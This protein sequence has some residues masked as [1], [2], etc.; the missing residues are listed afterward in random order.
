[1][2]TFKFAIAAVFPLAMSLPGCANWP[3]TDPQERPVSFHDTRLQYALVTG[4]DETLVKDFN[5]KLPPSMAERFVAGAVLPVTAATETLF[6]PFFTAIK[7][8][9]PAPDYEN[10][11]K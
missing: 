3:S 9:A 11:A 8:L 6:W 2:K 1:M 10:S 5:M 4:E 7:T